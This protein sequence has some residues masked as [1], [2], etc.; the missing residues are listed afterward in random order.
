MRFTKRIIDKK[1]YTISSLPIDQHLISI[2][3]L[4]EDLESESFNNKNDKRYL[5]SLNEYS[6]FLYFLI[7]SIENKDKVS[8][9][10]QEL[11]KYDNELESSEES[12]KALEN[13]VRK[14]KDSILIK[15][16]VVNYMKSF[17]PT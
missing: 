17:S 11:I 6:S 14:L 2:D 5:K 15:R 7:K 1:I 8:S 4:R 10:Y 16:N 3:K 13:K 9:L 12:L